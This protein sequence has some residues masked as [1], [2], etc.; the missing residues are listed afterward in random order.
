MMSYA[1]LAFVLGLAIYQ[2][3]VW[4]RNLD[5]NA[6][7]LDSRNVFIAYIVS[8][9]FCYLFFSFANVIKLIEGLLRHKGL[10]LEELGTRLAESIKNNRDHDDRHRDGDEP[11]QL[12]EYAS[13]EITPAP[14]PSIHTASQSQINT[15]RRPSSGIAAALEAAAR[16]HILSAEA[17]RR[18]ASEYAKLSG[19][20]EGSNR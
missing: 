14:A 7:K 4:T 19:P 1:I 16:A 8:T 9:G 5:T 20:Q 2:G 15:D 10:P 3:F 18:V 17:D 12:E 11:V 6:G 13:A